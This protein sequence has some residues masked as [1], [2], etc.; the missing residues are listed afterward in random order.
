MLGNAE[1]QQTLLNNR[2]AADVALARPLDGIVWSIVSFLKT[3]GDE[4][5]ST[6]RAYMLL[7]A[8][9]GGHVVRYMTTEVLAVQ[10]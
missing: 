4:T 10:M 5:L 8:V 2:L 1:I 7:F 9:N 6:K 3:L